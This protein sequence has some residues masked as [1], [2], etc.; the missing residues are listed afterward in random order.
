MPVQQVY[1]PDRIYTDLAEIAKERNI[2]V[3]ELI[4]TIIGQ[5]VNT[6]KQ[7]K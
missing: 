7:K 3:K 1:L 6:S 2:T 5:Y 4:Q